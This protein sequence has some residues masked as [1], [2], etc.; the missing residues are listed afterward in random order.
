MRKRL[1][2]EFLD[3]EVLPEKEQLGSV[4]EEVLHDHRVEMQGSLESVHLARQVP[5]LS[6]VHVVFESERAF[7]LVELGNL[8][9]LLQN[10]LADFR[11]GHGV[12][13][14]DKDDELEPLP[15]E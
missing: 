11:L 2:K 13:E 14:S 8:L 4:A 5:S 15:R 12:L 3:L 9:Q 1:G 7:V 10:F 6:H